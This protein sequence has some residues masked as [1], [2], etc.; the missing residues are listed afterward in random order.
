MKRAEDGRVYIAEILGRKTD[1]LYATGGRMVH[2]FNSISF[3]GSY[4]NI[5]QFQL[6]QE[7]YHNFT[8]I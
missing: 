3:L 5:K 6:I 8:W 2:Y 4:M 7:E 1:M